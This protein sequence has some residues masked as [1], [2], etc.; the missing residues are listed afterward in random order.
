MRPLALLDAPSNLGLHP[1]EEGSV[2]GCHKAPGALRDQGLLARLG[3]RDAGVLTPARY[4]AEWTPGTVR[5]EEAIAGYTRALAQRLAS[6]RT[7]GELPVVLGGDCS[8]LLGAGLA[9]RRTGRFGLA[10][11]DGHLDYRHPGNSI[12]VGA[13]AGEG[14]AL[15][16]GRGGALAELDAG[17]RPYLRPE[18]VVAIGFRPDDEDIEETA[19]AG[20]TLLDAAAVRADP[21][22]AARAALDRLSADHLDGF[23]V[24]VDVDVLDAEL[25]PAVDSPEPG[26]LDFDQLAAVLRPLLA[27]PLAAGVDLAI[28]DPDLD[29]ELA[30]A[31]R[32]TD[33]LVHALT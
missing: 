24:H 2:P 33:L 10:Y 30:G 14:L 4:R 8:V 26:G 28:Y 5:N 32:L 21:G 22:A 23:W 31:P 25:M 20:I 7:A 9:L 15:L 18:D 13:A 27:S 19:A 11:L 6:M 29:P 16:T 3:A 17:A 1:P 12:G